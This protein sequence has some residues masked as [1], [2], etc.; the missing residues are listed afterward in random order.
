MKGSF[1]FKCNVCQDIKSGELIKQTLD[2][3]KKE[4]TLEYTCNTCKISTPIT[5][6]MPKDIVLR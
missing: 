5:S 4:I 2:F 1:F 3:E 6:Q